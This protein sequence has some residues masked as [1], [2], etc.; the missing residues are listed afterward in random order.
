MGGTNRE[1]PATRHY[2][3][4]NAW[5]QANANDNDAYVDIMEIRKSPSQSAYI[6]WLIAND[7]LNENNVVREQQRAGFED[8]GIRVGSV[9]G[10]QGTQANIRGWMWDETYTDVNTYDT[11]VNHR[12]TYRRIYAHDTTARD[13]WFLGFG[14]KTYDNRD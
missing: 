5:L 2:R 12:D 4:S 9:D 7:N 6:Q 1:Q 11:G 8:N 3:V 14:A 10:G 13:I